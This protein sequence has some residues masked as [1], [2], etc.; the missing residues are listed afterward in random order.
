MFRVC[1]NAYI[2]RGTPAS[3][4]LEAEAQHCH[5]SLVDTPLPSNPSCERLK[6]SLFRHMLRDRIFGPVAGHGLGDGLCIVSYNILAD[7]Y[8]VSG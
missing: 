2:D 5:T 6:F 1:T 3:T 7:K 4:R 8:A